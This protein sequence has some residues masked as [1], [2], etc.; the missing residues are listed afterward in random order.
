MRIGLRRL[1]ALYT[2]MGGSHH[3][4]TAAEIIRVAREFADTAAK[5]RGRCM[6]IVG[7]GINHWYHTDMT[8]RGII[9][10]L[11]LC[12]TVGIP[13]GGWAHYVGQ[14]KLRPVAG[15]S[16]LA[17]A[18]DWYRPPRHMN[19]TSFFYNH[20]DQWRYESLKVDDYWRRA[21]RKGAVSISSIS[22]SAPSAWAGSLPRHSSR[23][24]RS[25]SLPRP[26]P[27]VSMRRTLWRGA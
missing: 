3:G 24:T 8:Y 7:S 22:T 26:M 21:S 4:R 19:G 10:V 25:R 15:W 27:P 2:G 23:G 13:G 12:G 6:A 9:N 18:L 5:S 1:D 14:E 20:T 17:F 16:T 11:M